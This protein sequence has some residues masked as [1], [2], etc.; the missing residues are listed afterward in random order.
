MKK[1]IIIAA[2]LFAM[3]C[4]KNEQS[5][6]TTMSTST[7]SVATQM[8]GTT[9]EEGFYIRGTVNGSEVGGTQF[10]VENLNTSNAYFPNYQVIRL[11]A[12]TEANNLEIDIFDFNLSDIKLP[13][14]VN[15]KSAA[16]MTLILK[17]EKM[18]SATGVDCSGPDNGCAF[19]AS[20]QNGGAS[21][22]ITAVDTVKHT[23]EGTFKGS[24]ILKGTG[25]QRSEHKDKAV[26][27]KDG[28]FKM[29]YRVDSSKN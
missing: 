15:E 25:F 5:A 18:I 6:T 26:E 14:E 19:M 17:E 10:N 24:L 29:H 7:D 16:N 27:I 23:I 22:T 12:G 11:Q 20:S 4:G 28:S 3:S 9:Y 13:F 1:S 21:A 8:P 2:A